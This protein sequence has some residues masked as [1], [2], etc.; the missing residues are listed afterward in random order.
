VV[1]SFT[2]EIVALLAMTN[3]LGAVPVLMAIFAAVRAEVL[4]AGVYTFMPHTSIAHQSS[5]I[6]TSPL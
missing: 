2:Q 4:L 6:Q 1:R 3:P 5:L